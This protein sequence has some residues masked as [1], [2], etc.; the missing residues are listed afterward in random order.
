[1]LA[2]FSDTSDAGDAVSAIVD[3]GLVPGAIEMMDALSIEAAEQATGAGYRLDAGAALLV[4]LDGPR[5]QCLAGLEQ[6]TRLCAEAGSLDVRIAQ[7][8]EERDL[9]WRTRKAAFASMGRIAPAYYV[10][11]GVIPRTRLSEVLRRID[12]LA[13]EYGMR[14]A[15]VFHAGDGNLHP[16]VCYDSAKEG[17]AA[18]AEEL[19]GLI[20]KTCVD[21]G[22]SITGEH[23]VGVDKKAYMPSMFSEPDLEAFQR[24]R[25]AFDPHGLAN[26]GK[27]MPTPRLCGEVPGHYREHPLE[28]AGI[29]ERF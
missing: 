19:S 26:P 3:A 2:F 5:E 17:E 27:V 25:C 13:Q 8:D 24:L 12:A 14:V 18:R 7:S 16:L 10:Q 23:G 11:D 29:A 22:G 4:E 20:M 15:N 1:M 6:L 28:R 9:I 21:A